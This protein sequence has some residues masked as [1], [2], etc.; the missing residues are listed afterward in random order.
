MDAVKVISELNEAFH[1][2]VSGKNFMVHGGNAEEYIAAAP[3]VDSE[4]KWNIMADIV[5]PKGSLE[6]VWVYGPDIN[7]KTTGSREFTERGDGTQQHLNLG[8]IDLIRTFLRQNGIE[9]RIDRRI[10]E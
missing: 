2:E 7:N 9:I 4:G 6:F 8:D 5:E 3:K 1:L 10:D